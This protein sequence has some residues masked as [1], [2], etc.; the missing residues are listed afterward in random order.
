[1]GN[2]SSKPKKVKKGETPLGYMVRNFE[3]LY[4]THDYGVELTKEK[5]TGMCTI[6][7]PLLVPDWPEQGSMDPALIQKVHSQVTG[8]CGHPEQYPYIDIWKYFVKDK[9]HFIMMAGRNKKQVPP[10]RE[11]NKKKRRLLVEQPE[12]I[13]SL[14]PPYPSYY[15]AARE[16][17]RAA[18][19]RVE[20]GRRA[21]ATAP[22]A[23]SPPASG[24]AEE[25]EGAVGGRGREV[26]PGKIEMPD[27]SIYKLV[28]Q[29]D[30]EDD[31]ESEE[32]KQGATTRAANNIYKPRDTYQH[33]PGKSKMQMP[34]REVPGPLLE[35]G[36]PGPVQYTYVPF[37]TTDLFNWKTHTPLYS[38]NPAAV[39]SMI[40]SVM[41]THN[42]TWADCQ[43]LMLTRFTTE[44][45]A[46]INSS[47]RKILLAQP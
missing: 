9:S 3:V 11:N 28:D 44:E 39:A 37:T 10:N 14:S 31:D 43:Q 21:A 24:I 5:L 4:T 16:A 23:S 1:M 33:N 46:R 41:L 45:R 29:E 12:E 6:V 8:K 42:P 25:D 19:A 2:G 47:A 27:G 36:A 20:G 38:I 26:P 22:P 40:E 34:L 35:N 13:D 32:V 7:W 17:L 18:F 30:S 15:G